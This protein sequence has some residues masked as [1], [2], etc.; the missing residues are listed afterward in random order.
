MGACQ[1]D[2][3]LS[4]E[5][6]SSK[7][8]YELSEVINLNAETKR[9]AE[10]LQD[11]KFSAWAQ[12]NANFGNLSDDYGYYIMGKLPAN[13][14]IS[15]QGKPMFLTIPNTQIFSNEP[16]IKASFGKTETFQISDGSNTQ[17]YSLYVP[18]T[19]TMNKLLHDQ[20]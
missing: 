5:S 3:E 20:S 16:T 19:I 12:S 15:L 8:S 17:S 1:K 4:N 13:I 18:K 11:N 7:T 14:T 6:S 9:L 10:V 2:S